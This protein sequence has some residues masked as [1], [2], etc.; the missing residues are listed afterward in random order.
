MCLPHLSGKLI[1]DSFYWSL[2]AIF[3]TVCWLYHIIVDIN[4]KETV[5]KTEKLLMGW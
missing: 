2:F 5:E 3:M 1:D 4:K